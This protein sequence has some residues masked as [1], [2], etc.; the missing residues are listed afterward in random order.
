M[1]SMP[2][3]FGLFFLEPDW[4]WREAASFIARSFLAPDQ[5]AHI[6]RPSVVLVSA[7]GQVYKD[8]LRSDVA[9][10]ST[11]AEASVLLGF[12][13]PRIDGTA[14]RSRRSRVATTLSRRGFGRVSLLGCKARPGKTFS[15]KRIERCVCGTCCVGAE[16]VAEHRENLPQTLHLTW[17]IVSAKKF[18]LSDAYRY[19][20]STGTALFA[21]RAAG[22]RAALSTPLLRRRQQSGL[23]VKGIPAGFVR[24]INIG[25]TTT[26]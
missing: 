24:N 16:T 20:C 1:R 9:P 25:W 6:P 11:P 19:K 5:F 18:S 4:C 17:L 2:T 14:D 12:V 26:R 3:E 22:S 21:R 23:I 8:R 13:G 10:S 15:R 7:E